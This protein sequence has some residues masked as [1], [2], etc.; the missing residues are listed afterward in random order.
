MG[1]AQNEAYTFRRLSTAD[2]LSQSSVIAIRQDHLGQMWFGTR[3]GLNK[4]D[5]T[6]F[7]VYRND[8]GDSLSISNSDILAIEEDSDGYIWVGTYNG[9]N[10]FDPRTNT[11]K[12]YFHTNAP[13][14][15][16]HN[17]ILCIR[18]LQNGEIWA[19]TANGLSVY[20]R[21]SDTFTTV[22]RKREE[23][24][25]LPDNFISSIRETRKGEVWIGTS[26]GI[27]RFLQRKEGR[28]SFRS[29]PVSARPATPLFVQDI[30]E[31]GKGNLWVGSKNR[32]L[33]KL[34]TD[35]GKLHPFLNRDKN[36]GIDKD[37]RS[38]AIDGEGILWVG[39]YHGINTISPDGKVRKVLN[40]PN[41]PSSLS[42]NTVKSVFADK[43]GSVWIG[44][45]YGGINIWDNANVNFT[46]Y[47]HSTDHNSLSYDVVSSMASDRRK[48]L[49]FGTEGGGI[50]VHNRETG[51]SRYINTRNGLPSNNI[52]SMHLTA[53]EKLWI[54]MFN[55]GIAVYDI[56]DG[57]FSDRQLPDS[58]RKFLEHTSI[59]AIAEKEPGVFWLGTFG[60]GLVRYSDK[61]DTFTVLKHDP[62]DP[63]TLSSDQIRTVLV[64]SKNAVWAGTQRGLSRI[65][66]HGKAPDEV[67]VKHFFY[68][69]ETLSGDDILTVFEDSNG[70]LWVGTK[71][72]GLFL[73][74]GNTFR[75][76]EIRPDNDIITAIHAIVE[77]NRGNL[78]LGSNQGIVRYDPGTGM[79]RL[80]SQK[81]GLISNEFN[82]NACLKLNSGRICFG[83]PMGV[84]SFDPQNIVVNSYAPPVIL[85]DLKVRDESV[86]VRKEGNI[87]DSSITYTR[88]VT[89]SYDKANFSIN[90][91]IPS[92][93]NPANNQYAYR[94][95]GLD[96]R[97]NTASGTEATY[98]IQN[99]GT[100]RFEV[101]GANNDGVWNDTP[102]TLEITVRPAPWRSWWAFSL[103]A[104]FIGLALYGLIWIMKSKARLKHELELE[105]LE[106]KRVKEV[107][108]AKLQF[109][110]NI[111][112]EFRTPLTLILGPLQ[113]LL[114]NYK[115]S[116]KMYK[117]LLVIE[118][119]ANHLLQLIN[120]LMDFRKLENSQSRLQSAEGN[121]VK[122]LR[123]IYLSFTEFAKAGKYS[124]TFDA[125]PEEIPVY[126]DRNKLEHVFYN[127]IS[128]AFRYTPNGGG[129]IVKVRKGKRN[130][131]VEVR[132]S[133][134]GI[135][136]EHID[137]IFDR[138]FEIGGGSKS[139]EVHHKG[140]GIGLFLAK[141]NVELHQGSIKARNRKSGGAAFKVKL[142]LGR[143]HLTEDDIL[144]DFRF[145]DDVSLYT[146]Q[147]EKTGHMVEEEVHDLVFDENKNTVLIVEDN[148]PLR[149]FI[150]NL[151]QKDYNV[152]EAGDGKTAMKKALKY[153]PDLVIS[154][155][156]M[157]EM[158]GTE[159]CASIKGHLKTS[160][161][162]V[163]L[164]TSR[165]SLV[166]KFEGL[167]SGADDYISKPFN[168]KEF[169]LRVRNLLE[170]TERLKSKFSSEDHLSPSEITVSSMD[171]KLLKK[172][173]KIVEDNI[174]DEQ[175]DIPAFCTEL[176]VSRTML[177]TKIKAWTNF[178]PNEFI[179]EI[180]MKR[181]VQLLEQD[182]LNVSQVSYKVGFRNP[183]YF[184][185]CFR[186]KYG[187]TPSE[188]VDKFSAN[189]V[190]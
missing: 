101:K 139:R 62:G 185:R 55:A 32:G 93:L 33:Y 177:F 68:D 58:L 97:W 157:P 158:V 133:G 39:T 34:D 95:I 102:T 183:K 84:S 171:E 87:L 109:F 49:Y 85:T 41:R 57:K 73:R 161:I 172:A 117:K 190:E 152:L 122:F 125:T 6:S 137:R 76:M 4:Y 67:R 178:T 26:G 66:F 11:F 2:G 132:D 145:S 110:T 169:C 71:S 140:T 24:N 72:R 127:L 28:F 47:S 119:S 50:T 141:S 27:C 16:N 170:S 159:L 156:I 100:Y 154:D 15:L 164:L 3:D 56:R 160:H 146:A 65:I 35:S 184:A 188:Y 108:Q 78:W 36:T 9:L 81:D 143:E 17:T 174:S 121:M 12:R 168:V 14:A 74:E 167:E 13:G 115:G 19:G 129:V 44:T 111:S 182:K 91:A 63:N 96:D 112:H 106:R 18:Q 75:N 131:I 51:Q 107:N 1:I 42:K 59:Y 61:D 94:L 163:I 155:V 54:G 80:Y 134:V 99:P 135:P 113:Q 70:Q 179:R 153:I 83:G 136:E 114:A 86:D 165:T 123:E 25:S 60:R 48:N 148:G 128:N 147:L 40:R 8:P 45:Y 88:A 173:L 120:R 166:Y 38:L 138:F 186:K 43:K 175:F 118:S 53:A 89:L 105:H 180:R 144:K 162:P 30:I 189:Y 92:Y 52:K 31:D 82:D 37:V 98:T 90:F 29:Y 7:T 142:P 10:R 126:Y 46:N 181:A 176:G 69:P 79:A 116:N 20:D 151:L 130:V 23:A 64:D 150:K 187:L 124:Y 5:G 22:T 103:Y 104:M 149:L 21:E 77:D